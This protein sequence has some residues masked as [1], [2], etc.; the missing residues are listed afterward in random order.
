[1]KIG[2]VHGMQC[3]P[4]FHSDCAWS[5]TCRLLHNAWWLSIT[6]LRT[7]APAIKCMSMLGRITLLGSLCPSSDVGVFR[8]RYHQVHHPMHSEHLAQLLP[9]NA[10]NVLI[11][12]CHVGK[13][14]LC[15]CLLSCIQGNLHACADY[16]GCGQDL[17]GGALGLHCCRA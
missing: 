12:V 9:L 17:Q 15:V 2:Q 11:N 7:C 13:G 6:I 1:M 10:T 8:L 14:P 5:N 3:M 4:L 16:T